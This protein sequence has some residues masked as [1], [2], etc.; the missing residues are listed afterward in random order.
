MTLY[1]LFSRCLAAEYQHSPYG[2]DYAVEREEDTL[3]IFLEHSDGAQD[4]GSNLNFAPKGYIRAG[5]VIYHAHGGFLQVW[6]GMRPLIAEATQDLNI[7]RIYVV[8]YSHGGALAALCHEFLWQARPDLRD[9][10]VS[11]GFAAPRVFWGHMGRRFR[12]KF[13]RFSVVRIPDDPVTHLPPR[14]LGYHHVGRMI[15]L[16]EAGKYRGVEGHRAEN[17]LRELQNL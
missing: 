8:G 1:T 2:G 10:L 11:Y 9:T 7:E 13:E 14:L 17:I 12:S 4:W 15:E 3:Y 16:C 5:Q 6:E